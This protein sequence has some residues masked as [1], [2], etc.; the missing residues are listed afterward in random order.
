MQNKIKSILFITLLSST[1]IT[2]LNAMDP[3]G[4]SSASHQQAQQNNWVIHP[5]EGELGLNT[6]SG[7]LKTFFVEN[8]NSFPKFQPEAVKTLRDDSVVVVKLADSFGQGIPKDLFVRLLGATAFQ[9]RYQNVIIQL[10]QNP[11]YRLPETDD[12]NIKWDA[13]KAQFY[14][15]I[16][17]FRDD[18]GYKVGAQVVSWPAFR[19][20]ITV[21]VKAS[22]SFDMFMK[23]RELAKQ[24]MSTVESA[25]NQ[26]VT[27]KNRDE[28]RKTLTTLLNKIRT[29]NFKELE[30]LY[31]HYD[32]LE[33]LK[34]K[35]DEIAM[36]LEALGPVPAQGEVLHIIP[37]RDLTS[38]SKTNGRTERVVLKYNNQKVLDLSLGESEGQTYKLKKPENASDD[39]LDHLTY[40][41]YYRYFG[42]PDTSIKV[43]ENVT[44]GADPLHRSELALYW[45]V[46]RLGDLA[47]QGLKF[48][49]SQE[50]V[51]YVKNFNGQ[52]NITSD[53]HYTPEFISS[54]LVALREKQSIIR[55]INING[56]QLSKEDWKNIVKMR[57][58]TINTITLV[59]CFAKPEDVLILF[60]KEISE[61]SSN[62]GISLDAIQFKQLTI[63]GSN[64]TRYAEFL[65][66]TGIIRFINYSY[67][68][69]VFDPPQIE[70][71]LVYRSQYP[72]PDQ[73]SL[74]ANLRDSLEY[75]TK[76]EK[77]ARKSLVTFNKWNLY[78]GYIKRDPETG[79]FI[80][81]MS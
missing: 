51:T 41:L 20:Y 46:I 3:A 57:S 4:A 61:Q 17:G 73:D 37:S 76:A 7:F 56:V 78:R 80:F 66:E 15:D 53:D 45:D 38:A 16:P 43:K 12:S 31:G 40:D 18:R 10:L 33:W 23:A 19:Q 21:D 50:V 52:L 70:I 59:D 36:R 9:N 13:D 79:R 77:T 39:W 42:G 67:V 25:L 55:E 5:F 1:A 28:V 58:R 74:L 72:Q 32:I 14:V 44:L 71:N 62:F 26:Q 49:P 64:I 35:K 54:I 34:N 68:G 69:A 29:I 81:D 65:K 27:A 24:G 60:P 2:S 63:G 6:F 75:V 22:P 30:N 11:D 8:G 47:T 48:A